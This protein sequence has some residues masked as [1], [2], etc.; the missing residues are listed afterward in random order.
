MSLIEMKDRPQLVDV[1]IRLLYVLM[2]EKKGRSRG[3][4]RRA[5]VLTAM[6][7]CTDQELSLLVDLMLNRWRT[8]QT[9]RAN[10]EKHSIT[11]SC[12]P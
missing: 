2:L 5:T 12:V 11:E 1:I 9:K 6:A 7:G 3:G 4:D 8:M 10:P